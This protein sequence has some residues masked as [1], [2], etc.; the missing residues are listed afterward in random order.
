MQIIQLEPFLVEERRRVALSFVTT[1]T[2]YCLDEPTNPLDAESVLVR[3]TFSA[4]F[5][6]SYRR[7]AR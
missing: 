1:T 6:N 7:N 4:I 2:C 5:R 3:A